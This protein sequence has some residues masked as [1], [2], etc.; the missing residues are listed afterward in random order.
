MFDKF[1]KFLPKFL[2]GPYSSK[3]LGLPSCCGVLV[4][5]LLSKLHV[6]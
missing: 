4:F 6:A 3:I 2:Q 1:F 5:Q